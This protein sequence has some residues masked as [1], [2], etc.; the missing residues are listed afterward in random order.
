MKK[1]IK[2]VLGATGIV[3]LVLGVAIGASAFGKKNKIHHKFF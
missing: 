2:K 1:I 3:A